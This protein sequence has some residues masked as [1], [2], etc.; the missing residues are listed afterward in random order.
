MGPLIN[1]GKVCLSKIWKLQVYLQKKQEQ[2]RFDFKEKGNYKPLA[3]RRDPNKATKWSVLQK[4]WPSITWD[5][6]LNNLDLD[7]LPDGEKNEAV[8]LLEEIRKY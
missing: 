5:N 3:G 4:E 8:E 1:P 6:D 7:S 2:A